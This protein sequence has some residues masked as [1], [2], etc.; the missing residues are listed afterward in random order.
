MGSSKIPVRAQIGTRGNENGTRGKPGGAIAH[1]SG[2][3]SSE[4][5]DSP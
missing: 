5:T 3:F 4:V 2:D 1:P